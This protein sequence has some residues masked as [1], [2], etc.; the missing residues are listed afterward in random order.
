MATVNAQLTIQQGATFRQAIACDLSDKSI[1]NIQ[2]WAT[3]GYTFTLS[4]GLK[5]DSNFLVVANGTASAAIN[6]VTI[7]IDEAVTAAIS[8]KNGY[9]TLEAS[10][11]TDRW[12]LAEGAWFL[13][14]DT[15]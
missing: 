11:G 12:R 14:R 1:A 3:A 7:D 6:L 2:T 4:R 8:Q 9:W 5:G 13:S 10:N 15:A